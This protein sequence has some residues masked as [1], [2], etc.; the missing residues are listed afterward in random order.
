MTG[1]ATDFPFINR[2]RQRRR[3]DSQRLHN[4]PANFR[5]LLANL[6]PPRVLTESRRRM[7]SENPKP[8]GNP[9][10]QAVVRRHGL[11]KLLTEGVDKI[12]CHPLKVVLQDFLTGQEHPADNIRTE[13]HLRQAVQLIPRNL[14]PQHRLHAEQLL[15]EHM[16]FPPTGNPAFLAF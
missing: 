7:Q 11:G 6:L 16:K 14:H 4:G 5:A 10:Q 2:L 15:L 8:A 9:R 13:K 3:Q 12:V 1:Q